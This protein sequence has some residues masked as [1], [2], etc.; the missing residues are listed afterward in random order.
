MVNGVGQGGASVI[1]GYVRK[2]FRLAP[3]VGSWRHGG[4]FPPRFW[5]VWCL[6]LGVCLQPSRGDEDKVDFAADLARIHI[7]MIGGR[8]KVAAL[9]GLRATGTTNISGGK[10]T[11]VLW[12][13]RPNRVRVETLGGDIRITRGYDGV[14]PPWM[15]LAENHAS[16]QPPEDAAVFI[17]DAEFDDPLYRAKERGLG[18]HYTG[19]VQVHGIEWSRIEVTAPT[20]KAIWY[21]DESYMLVRRD[22]KRVMRDKEVV[23]ET[24]YSDF[25]SVSG[26]LLPHLIEVRVGNNVLHETKLEDIDA[27]P[28]LLPEFFKRP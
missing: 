21:L 3:F 10:L 1:G 20:G 8:D 13:Q 24:Y 4:M 5:F 19:A 18:L 7:E 27:N 12:A 26:V 25:R 28:F 15:R 23:E 2:S 14:H 6:V 22:I 11:F 17:R 9:T 16:E